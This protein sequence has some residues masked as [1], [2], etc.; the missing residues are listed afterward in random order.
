MYSFYGSVVPEYDSPFQT[1]EAFYN[2]IAD[3]G[4]FLDYAEKHNLIDIFSNASERF[5]IEFVIRFIIN[6]AYSIGYGSIPEKNDEQNL[7][8]QFIDDKKLYFG[9][10]TEVSIMQSYAILAYDLGKAHATLAKK[11]GD[12]CTVSTTKQ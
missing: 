12:A 1:F 3:S 11:E 5:V 8:C 9:K 7:A 4:G 10:L 2:N 6:M